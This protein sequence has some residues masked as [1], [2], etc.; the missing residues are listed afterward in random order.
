FDAPYTSATFKASAI[1]LDFVNTVIN[2]GPD[3]VV[4]PDDTWHVTLISGSGANGFKDALGTALDGAANAGAAN[5][6]TSFTTAYQ[7][8]ATPVLGIPDFARGPDSSAVIKVP[9]NSAQGIPVTLY[10]AA[11][12]TDVVFTLS[13]N[14]VL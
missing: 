4:L 3:S 1:P 9:N 7:S 10:N 13:F 12:V 14:P 5:Y 2:S 8:H 6:T 11:A